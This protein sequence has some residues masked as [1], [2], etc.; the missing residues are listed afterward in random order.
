MQAVTIS[1]TFSNGTSMHFS[2]IR[3]LPYNIPNARSTAILVLDCIK[4]HCFSGESPL[5]EPLNERI[6]Q[7]LIRYVASPIS[8]Y[9]LNFPSKNFFPISVLWNT[10]QS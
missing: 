10:D 5:F 8:L 2:R 4:F 3:H 1:G 7:S 9:G 6:K